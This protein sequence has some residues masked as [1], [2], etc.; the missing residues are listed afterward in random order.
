MG[1]VK[2]GELVHEFRA[3]PEAD[4]TAEILRAVGFLPL[5]D[6]VY[7]YGQAGCGGGPCAVIVN[8]SC[9]EGAVC[10]GKYCGHGRGFFGKIRAGLQS[11]YLS[12][13]LSGGGWGQLLPGWQ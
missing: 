2:E 9:V 13:P 7:M 6:I 11:D 10:A 4:T 3:G 12:P 1:L 8:A 5:D